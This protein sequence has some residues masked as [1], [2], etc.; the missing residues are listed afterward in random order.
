LFINSKS[1]ASS[2]LNCPARFNS[3]IGVVITGRANAIVQDNKQVR[4]EQGIAFSNVYN[5]GTGYNGFG[6]FN[7]LSSINLPIGFGAIKRAFNIDNILVIVMEN[8]CFSVYVDKGILQGQDGSVTISVSGQVV[9][10]YRE[11]AGIHGTINP[12]SFASMDGLLFW[13]D[14]YRG[15]VCQYGSDGI[16]AVSGY[17]MNT[18][19]AIKGKQQLQAFGPEFK[20]K[21]AVIKQFSEYVL[22]FPE[23]SIDDIGYQRQTLVFNFDDNRWKGEYSFTPEMLT[24]FGVMAISF[25]DGELW[26]HDSDVRGNF[27]GTQYPCQLRWPVNVAEKTDKN[28]MSIA[29]ESNQVPNLPVITTPIS[30]L[31]LAG[32]LSELLATDF[33]FMNNSYFASFMNNKLTPNFANQ[34]EAL[35]NGDSIVGQILLLFY[36]KESPDQLVLR[37]ARIYYNLNELTN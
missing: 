37:S 1:V 33:E 32:Q 29:I 25:V 21:G 3:L 24:S 30:E 12:E 14:A 18:P 10:A 20:V 34:N 6:T 7:E 13:W 31:N 9:G 15:E 2:S 11:L 23:Y 8:K 26:I 4:L 36:S 17:K 22:C 5:F 27:Y 16:T 28:F 35:A 19:F